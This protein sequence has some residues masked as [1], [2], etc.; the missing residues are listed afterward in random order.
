MRRFSNI[1]FSPL[2]RHDNSLAVRNF[3]KL[4]VGSSARVV[5]FGAVPGPSGMRRLFPRSA[6]DR[7]LEERQREA[8]ERELSTWARRIGCSSVETIVEVGKPAVAIVER[9]VAD[10]HDLV[11]VTSDDDS[12]DRAAIRRLF[13]ICPCPVW[14]IRPTRARKLRVMAAINPDPDERD[15]NRQILELAGSMVELNGGDLHVAHAWE[16]FGEPTLRSSAFVHTSA[17]IVDELVDHERDSR[18]QAIR[19]LLTEPTI[20]DAPWQVHLVKGKPE[21]VVPDLADELRINLVVMGTVARSGLSG[22]VIGN[23]AENILDRVRCSV[24]AIKPP[25]F[26]SPIATPGN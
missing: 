11:V 2:G 26:V 20:A 13:R 1:L 15:L 9:V 23:T 19:E 24:I 12:V 8:T 17:E 18:R 22:L 16:L 7:E 6:I 21:S 10:G 3:S 14:V 25:G 5:M 4:V